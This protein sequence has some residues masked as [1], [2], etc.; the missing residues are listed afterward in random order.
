MFALR[1]PLGRWGAILRGMGRMRG[2]GVVAGAVLVAAAVTACG[3]DG[4]PASVESSSPPAPVTSE[5]VIEEPSPSEPEFPDTPEGELDKKAEKEGWVVDS[6]Y[7]SASEYVQDICDSLPVSGAPGSSRPQWLASQ[8]EGDRKEMLEA[9]IPK[10]CPEWTKTL[11][12]AVSGEYERWYGDGEYEVRAKPD[13]DESDD[14]AFIQPGTYRTRGKLDNC[15]WERAT[16]AGEIIDNSF[17]N[18]ARDI[19]VTIRPSDGLFKSEGC[20]IWKPVK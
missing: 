3:G 2:V 12:Q 20:G 4:D 17:A 9:G 16:R 19:T 10:L 18:A 13:P 7:G 6:L 11:K 14:E 15:Y 1:F 8:L 5:P